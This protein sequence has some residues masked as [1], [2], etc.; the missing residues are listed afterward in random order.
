[1]AKGKKTGGR[2]VTAPGHRARQEQRR[3]LIRAYVTVALVKVAD[4]FG[5]AYKGPPRITKRGHGGD[6]KKKKYARVRCKPPSPPLHVGS[7]GPAGGGP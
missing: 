1:M 6:A 3:E 5:F 7:R 2:Q 4:R